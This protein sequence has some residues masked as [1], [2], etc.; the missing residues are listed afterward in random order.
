MRKPNIVITKFKF[1]DLKTKGLKLLNRG[2]FKTS[3]WIINIVKKEEYNLKNVQLPIR[4]SIVSVKQ[5]GFNKPTQLKKIYQRAKK[6]K[7]DLV[8]P[9]VAIYSRFIYKKQKV[10]EWIRFATP[11]NSMIDTD[12]VPHLPKFG[13][14]LGYYFLETY[15]SYPK[16][17]F[18]PKNKF[19]FK[20]K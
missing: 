1:H 13:R 14:A 10:G 8:P 12:N 7:L 18:H 16:A 4:L 15:W 3:L 17:I 6:R 2:K 9:E 19:F 20:I 11:L 5:L